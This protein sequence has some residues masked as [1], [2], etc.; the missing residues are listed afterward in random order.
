MTY[1]ST[2][3]A[4]SAKNAETERLNA[5]KAARQEQERKA[6]ATF[7]TRADD[8]KKDIR[9]AIGATSRGKW[10]EANGSLFDARSILNEFRETSVEQSDGWRDL[11]KQVEDQLTRIQ[12]QVD[13]L[14]EKEQA[15]EARTGGCPKGKAMIDT[16]TGK[17][18]HCTGLSVDSSAA[19]VGAGDDDDIHSRSK[20]L[21]S[22]DGVMV[23]ECRTI[24]EHADIDILLTKSTWEFLGENGRHKAFTQTA[25]ASFQGALETV[26]P[27]DR[28]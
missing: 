12:P 28:H 27:L 9:D 16:D 3:F 4:P 2:P 17:M 20:A 18:I 1:A 24:L 25:L 10:L 6:A 5:Q 7:P 19:T 13:R 21:E 15:L 22:W 11:A 26:P 8:I 23:M 14:T